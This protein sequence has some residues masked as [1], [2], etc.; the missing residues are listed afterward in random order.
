M[1]LVSVF[2]EET[3]AR[4]KSQ[5]PTAEQT[6]WWIPHD[7]ISERRVAAVLLEIAR[8]LLSHAKE[9]PA[10]RHIPAGQ[11]GEPIGGEMPLKAALPGVGK[12]P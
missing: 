9:L 5:T 1:S 7:P 11:V 10:I 8:C 6:S 4:G 3:Q 12:A 2:K